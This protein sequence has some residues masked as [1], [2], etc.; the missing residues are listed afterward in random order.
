MGLLRASVREDKDW[1]QLW[2]LDL[3]VMADGP[4]EADMLFDLRRRLIAE[5][6]LAM[7]YGQTPFVRLLRPGCPQA[8]IDAWKSRDDM[9]LRE[10]NL[11]DEVKLALSAVFRWAQPTDPQVQMGTQA[12]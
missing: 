1:W 6:H 10:L 8:V 7:R 3:F 2:L 12:A 5:Y 11:P 4:T 9:R